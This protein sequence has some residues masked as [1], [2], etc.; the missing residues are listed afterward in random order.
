MKIAV[1][2]PQFSAKVAEL[3]PQWDSTRTCQL[4][5]AGG[6]FIVVD[7]CLASGISRILFIQGGVKSLVI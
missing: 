1:K 5:G 2:F 6:M 3:C 4:T 7:L